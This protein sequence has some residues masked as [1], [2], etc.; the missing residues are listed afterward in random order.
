MSERPARYRVT[1]H[2]L[3]NGASTNVVDVYGSAFITAV[4][5]ITTDSDDDIVEVHL[6]DSGPNLQRCTAQAIA[7]QYLPPKRRR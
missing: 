6:N 7:D 2:Q 4:T 5:T 1:F 3:R